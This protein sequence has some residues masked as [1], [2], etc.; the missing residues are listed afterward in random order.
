[1]G[2]YL[3]APAMG[4][5]LGAQLVRLYDPTTQHLYFGTIGL[6]TLGAAGLLALARRK[7]K[8]RLHGLP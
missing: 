8:M 4:Q 1:M 2:L 7:I 5:G 3:L 6:A